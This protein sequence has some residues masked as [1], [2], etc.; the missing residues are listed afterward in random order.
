LNVLVSSQIEGQMLE[1]FPRIMDLTLERIQTVYEHL[2]T[3][4]HR[5]DPIFQQLQNIAERCNH[6]KRTASVTSRG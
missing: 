6:L 2:A 1:F 3:S 4:R 5:E